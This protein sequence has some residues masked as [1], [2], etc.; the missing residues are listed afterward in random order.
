LLST[1][2]LGI[3]YE[4][5]NFCQ[6]S[7]TIK[8]DFRRNVC[9][10]LQYVSEKEERETMGREEGMKSERKK[11]IENDNLLTPAAT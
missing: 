10:T 1:A 2:V 4:T 3:Y 5:E 7:G 11:E 9:G 8:L 6:N